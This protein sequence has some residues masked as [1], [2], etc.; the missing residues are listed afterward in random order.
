MA[1]PFGVFTDID[2]TIANIVA[3]PEEAAVTPGCRRSLQSLVDGL[4]LVAIVTGRGVE[5][6]RSMVQVK[7]AVYIG[8]HGLERWD[9]AGV[10]LVPEAEQYRD[11]VQEAAGQLR[12]WLTLPGIAVEEKGVGISVHYR[13]SQDWEHAHGAILSACTELGLDTWL[14]VQPGRAVL[15]LKIPIKA[16][17]GTA[18]QELVREFGLRGG[19]VLGD[20]ITDIDGFRAVH[21]LSAEGGF[22]GISVAV[23]EEG[24]P[25]EVERE[26]MY[27]LSGVEGAER[28][29]VRLAAV[30]G[31][32]RMR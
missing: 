26:G 2:G 24:T 18:I 14:D 23:T 19:I 32:G 28:F 6:A 12:Q 22:T 27:S 10:C 16:D 17:K 1:V 4:A 5:A 29:L 7:G 15:N 30:S 3:I 21:R 25:V 20:D 9:E 13:G 31:A 11:R 8:N